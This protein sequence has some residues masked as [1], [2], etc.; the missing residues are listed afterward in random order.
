MNEYPVIL[1]PECD[2]E[3]VEIAQ[4]EVV[5]WS[6]YIGHDLFLGQSSSHPLEERLDRL[7]ATRS[8]PSG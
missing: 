6:P 8:V 7:F 4:S 1:G 2:E 5:L 3:T